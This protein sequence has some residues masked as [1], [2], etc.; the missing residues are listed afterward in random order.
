LDKLFACSCHIELVAI[1][2]T[3]IKK[4]TAMVMMDGVEIIQDDTGEPVLRACFLPQL[5]SPTSSVIP[6]QGW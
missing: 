2:M 6:D 5:R 3:G 4:R 1:V